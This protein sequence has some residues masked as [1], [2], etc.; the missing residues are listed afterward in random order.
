LIAWLSK[1]SCSMQTKCGLQLSM[2]AFDTTRLLGCCALTATA[3][4]NTHPSILACAGSGRCLCSFVLCCTTSLSSSIPHRSIRSRLS[5]DRNYETRRDTTSERGAR[6]RTPRR[7]R[8]ETADAP[9]ATRDRTG[10]RGDRTRRETGLLRLVSHV[11]CASRGRIR[12][13]LRL[14]RTVTVLYL[15]SQLSDVYIRLNVQSIARF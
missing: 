8:A 3:H 10:S 12:L 9:T 14:A 2:R 7:R 6:G 5:R 11:V 15:Y 1:I 13:R 4:T